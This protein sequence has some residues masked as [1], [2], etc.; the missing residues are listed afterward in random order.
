LPDQRQLPSELTESVEKERKHKETKTCTAIAIEPV[1]DPSR[2]KKWLTL[3][4]VTAYVLRCVAVFK[5][6]TSSG[7]KEL[8]V[9][10]LRNAKL[11]W[12]R[13]IQRDVY[14]VEYEQLKANH[15]LPNTSAIL[16]LDPYY[17]KKD[18]LLRVGGR[19]Q[20]SDLP[21]GTKNPIILRMVIQWLK[22]SY[23]VCTMSSFML[24]PRVP[25]R[26]YDKRFG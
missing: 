22:R 5:S 3:I 6:G 14:Q 20:Y 7:S 2:Y 24:D 23:R 12:Y 18:Q 16:K 10:E 8:S 9:E 21:E 11:S 1:I 25:F 19:L 13:Q 15:P 4:R 26:F 17:D